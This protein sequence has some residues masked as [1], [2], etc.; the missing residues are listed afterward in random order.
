M[1]FSTFPYEVLIE[2]GFHKLQ[3]QSDS[4]WD[5]HWLHVTI[6]NRN[7]EI[8]FMKT[9]YYGKITLQKLNATWLHKRLAKDRK[10]HEQRIGKQLDTG[11]RSS[12]QFI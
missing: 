10:H 7:D 11:R 6:E 2:R 3:V 9:S 5:F 4:R 12:L 1:L 8:G